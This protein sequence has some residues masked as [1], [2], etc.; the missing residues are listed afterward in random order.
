[1]RAVYGNTCTQS[2]GKIQ[3]LIQAA[4][5]RDCAGRYAFAVAVKATHDCGLSFVVD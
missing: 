5:L 2:E 3:S 1:M 4:N